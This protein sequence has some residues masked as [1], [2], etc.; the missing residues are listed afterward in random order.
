MKR[1]RIAWISLWTLMSAGMLIAADLP[2]PLHDVKP[3]LTLVGAAKLTSLFIHVY[4]IALYAPESTYT[5]NG[6][7]VLC[8]RYNIS[9]K[10]QRLQ[11]TTLEEWRR[12]GKGDDVQLAQ[13]IKQLDSLWPDVKSGDRLTAYMVGNGTTQFY[14]GDRLLG[15]ITDSAF[16]PAFFAIWLD[17]NCSY[18]KIRDELMSVKEA[19]EK[20]R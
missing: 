15:E 14:F 4:D 7:A 11:E 5:T 18:P 1:L 19:K 16:G 2:A 6:T 13:W 10:R 12:L 3:A 17:V 20:G 9:I 8:I